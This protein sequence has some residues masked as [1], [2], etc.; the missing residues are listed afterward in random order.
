MLELVVIAESDGCCLNAGN[1]N[2][3]TVKRA[4]PLP[5]IDG[6]LSRLQ[7]THFISA[8]DLKDDFWQSLLDKNWQ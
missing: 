8:M 5:H 7:N 4:Y 2:E 3:H 6:L 1:I